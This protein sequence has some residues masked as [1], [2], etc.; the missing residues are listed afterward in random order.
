MY[1][2]VLRNDEYDCLVVSFKGSPS[3]INEVKEVV[4]NLGLIIE[5]IGQKKYMIF[6]FSL[7]DLDSQYLKHFFF[8]LREYVCK[9]AIDWCSV[10]EKP[11]EDYISKVFH[12]TMKQTKPM[13]RSTK[14]AQE[15]LGKQ[16][17]K[18]VSTQKSSKENTKNE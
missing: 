17:A 11:S 9:Y 4:R 12:Y 18:T 7:M 5:S 10:S 1:V 13:F 6:N 14:S 2:K 15:W 8:K 3:S 16:I